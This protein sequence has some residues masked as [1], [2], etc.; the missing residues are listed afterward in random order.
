MPKETERRDPFE[1]FQHPFAKYQKIEGGPFGAKKFPKEVQLFRKKLKGDPLVSPGIVSRKKEQPFWFSSLGQMLQYDIIKF[2]ITIL[3][4]SCGLKKRLTIIVAFHFM[5]SEVFS[6][7]TLLST[8]ASSSNDG[9]VYGFMHEVVSY[10]ESVSFTWFH[11][12]S[13]IE[14]S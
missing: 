13:C 1:I 7:S 6:Q 4:S 8:L 12:W 2:C 14:T 11:A 5:N 9:T 10:S 3:A